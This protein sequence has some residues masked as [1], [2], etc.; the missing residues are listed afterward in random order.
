MIKLIKTNP[1]FNS[2][3]TRSITSAAL[4]ITLAGLISRLMGLLRDSLLASTFSAG[5]TL[6]VYY[7]AFRIPDLIY[8]LLILGALSAAFIPIFTSLISKDDKEGAWEMVNDVLNAAVIIIVVLS[9]IFF[10]FAP[11]IMKVI[12][13][14]FDP[15]KINQV[16][17]LARIMFLSPLLLGIS[18]I[19][20]GVLTS[21]KRFLVYSIAPLFYNLGIIIGIVFFVKFMGPKGLAWGVVFGALLHAMFQYPAARNLG[22]RYHWP[23]FNFWR[24]KQLKRVVRLM[25]P[26]TL[27]I[28][29]SQ[30]N[31]M[32]ITIFASLLASG[33]LAIFNLAQNLQ[34]VALGLFGSSFAI[35]VFPNLSA[36]HAKGDK[37]NFVKDFSKTMRQILF[38]IIPITIGILLLRAQ[39]VRVALGHGKF[40]WDSTVLTFQVLAIFTLSLFAQCLVPLL[41]RTFYAMHDTRTPF[42]VALVSEA[43]NIIIV[44]SFIAKYQIMAL[45][46]AFSLAATVQMILL[47]FLLRTKFDNLDDKNII[48]TVIKIS[49][50]SIL[51]GIGIQ[52]TKYIIASAISIDTFIG[53]FIQLAASGLVGVV[54]FSLVSY[55]FKLEEF[56]E[57]QR[58]FTKR[59]FKSRKSITEDT[60]EVSGII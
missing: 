55:L 4:I 50:A 23:K 2:A 39:I 3:P 60:S 31:L 7:A 32:I 46:M 15:E 26:R 21:F 18:G 53:I 14:G 17:S 24:N 29:V 1:L 11:W 35:A 19:F 47:L 59:I 40:D 36:M 38:F 13:P 34:G 58:A 41:A 45:A 42:Y 10:A 48:R 44:I 16:V 30:V 12:T 43:V 57:F 51:A 37:E 52:I 56:M 20:G 22:Y 5:D 6:D 8:N 49:F 27:G 9:L 54:I 28:A 33:S 25:I